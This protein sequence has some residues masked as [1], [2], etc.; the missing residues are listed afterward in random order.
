MSEQDI[1]LTCGKPLSLPRKYTDSCGEK[2]QTSWLAK[3]ERDTRIREA[4]PKLLEALQGWLSVYRS[5]WCQPERT[6][7]NLADTTRAA[8]AL[9]SPQE[10]EVGK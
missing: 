7:D 1:C 5:G 6:I 10:S 3:Y 4:A 9:A 8:I 2:C